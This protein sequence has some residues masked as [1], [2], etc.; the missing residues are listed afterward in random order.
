MVST[1][2]KSLVADIT[3]VL[4]MIEADLVDASA[5][6][7]AIYRPNLA[8]AR[9][10]V[11]EY[12]KLGD[13]VLHGAMIGMGRLTATGNLIAVACMSVAVLG[14]PEKAMRYLKEYHR[15]LAEMSSRHPAD[16]LKNCS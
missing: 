15:L 1:T 5:T 14:S 9:R 12:G 4:D 6:E 7:E 16:V 10:I 13:G 8:E 2:K 3:E 11:A